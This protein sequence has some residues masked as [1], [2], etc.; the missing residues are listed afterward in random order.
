MTM[1][2]ERPTSRPRPRLRTVEVKRLEQVSPRMM[3]VTLTG[4]DLDGFGPPGPGQHIKV[5]FP[6]RGQEVPLLPIMGAE[7]PQF[8]SDQPRP[9]SRTYTPRRWRPETTELDI[10]IVLHGEGL[11]SDWAE[12]AH[13]GSVLVIAGPGGR[14]RLNTE[15]DWYVLGAD[16][17]GVPAMSAIIETLPAT[18]R[19]LAVA[20]VADV[21]DERSYAG[22]PL[23]NIRWLHGISSESHSSSALERALRELPIPSDGKGRAWI[24]CESSTMH[25]I[26]HYL[27]NEAGLDRDVIHTQGYWKVGVVNHPDHDYG[28][29]E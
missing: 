19:I 13:A 10:E 27:L 17:V 24:G 23:L 9:T 14:F 25:S 22:K 12:R 16:L 11:G 7:G 8:P 4:P 29:D 21:A 18:A 3:R 2:N 28:D 5:F 1:T 26:R 20:E 15:A 6:P